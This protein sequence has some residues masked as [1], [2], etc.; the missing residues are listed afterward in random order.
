MARF[1]MIASMTTSL[2]ATAAARSSSRLP[3]VTSVSN[4]GEK[5]AA[6]FALRAP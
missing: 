3:M 6:G 1:S 4:R 2:A 5:K